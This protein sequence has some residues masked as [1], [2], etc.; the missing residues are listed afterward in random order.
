MGSI[1]PVKAIIVILF[2]YKLNFKKFTS[3]ANVAKKKLRLMKNPPTGGGKPPKL[4]PPQE[5]W[6]NLHRES[7]ELRGLSQGFD[8]A[9]G[10]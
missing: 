5:L 6:M 9:E 10:S 3:F 7:S 8:L 1:T 2:F 4:T